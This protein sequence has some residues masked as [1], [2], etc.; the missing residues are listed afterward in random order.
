MEITAK[1][2]LIPNI[3]ANPYLVIDADGLTLIDA[4]LPGSGRKIL[5]YLAGLGW[6]PSDLKRIIITHSDIDHVGGLPAVK[7]ASGAR[8]YA[9]A[10]EAEAM[11]Q[12][13]PSRDIQSKKLARRLLLGILRPLVKAAPIRV[14][15][16]LSAGQVLPVLGGLQVLETPGHTPGHI[17]LYSP[18]T[19]ILFSGDSI[20]S[21]DG[22]LLRSIPANTWDEAKA[23]E[24][25]RRQAALG[26]QIV[27]CGHG[28]VIRD[29]AGKFPRV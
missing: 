25:A 4:G 27:C 22:G 29:A 20:V 2:H 8:L 6:S 11:A 1:V 21:R 15:E 7:K 3:I 18:S 9:S 13:H 24:S 14:D 19:G 23:D 5:H 28:A 10:I 16:I 12:G 17:S 26:A